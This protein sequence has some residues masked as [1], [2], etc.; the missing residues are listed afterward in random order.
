MTRPLGGYITRA[1]RSPNANTAI[2]IWTLSEAVQFKR[3]GLWP[4]PPAPAAPPAADPTPY[5]L[6]SSTQLLLPS[7]GTNGSTSFP[8]SSSA[9]RSITAGNTTVNTSVKK[10]GTGSAN[11]GSSNNGYLAASSQFSIAGDF[12]IECWAY[13]TG[14]SPS[15]YSV[16]TGSDTV[17]SQLPNFRSDFSI[18]YYNNGSNIQSSTNKFSLNTWFHIATVRSSNTVKIYVDGVEVVSGT[19]T[20]TLFIKNIS[21]YN[22][23]S[24]GY[25]IL[26]YLDDIRVCNEAVYTSSFTPPTAAH[27]T[28][29]TEFATSS[30]TTASSLRGGSVADFFSTGSYGIF[31][32]V[33]AGETL[34][35]DY[36]SSVNIRSV[37][38]RNAVGT[39][40][41]PTSV[42]IQSSTDG[43]NW[44]T[45]ATYSDNNT[46]SEQFISIAP[47][48]FARYWRLYQNSQTRQNSGG[49][50]WHMSHFSMR[51]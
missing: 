37:R 10:Y 43:T 33:N 47:G 22:G 17:N 16:L 23:G 27:P 36:G 29:T 2:G 42:L 46:T 1:D 39:S 13:L 14:I 30:N 28:S 9:G 12:T 6:Y 20:N 4:S 49:Y 7:D 11:F 32:T 5:A 44:T 50:E 51:A 19:D 45:R 34:T 40:W 35:M 41:A 26:G 25:N 38:Y 48:I 15:G 31:N 21:G 8:D 18:Q 24:S 3:A